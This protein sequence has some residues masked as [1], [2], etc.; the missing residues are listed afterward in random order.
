VVADGRLGDAEDAGKVGNRGAGE[1][2]DAESLQRKVGD[3]VDQP[4]I[5]ATILQPE[6]RSAGGS[7]CGGLEELEEENGRWEAVRR[8]G[9]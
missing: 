5:C 3:A 9:F 2:V 8:D 7:E 1:A 4:F 6:R